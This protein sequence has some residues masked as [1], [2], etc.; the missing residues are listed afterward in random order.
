LARPSANRRG[1]SRSSRCSICSCSQCSAAP[2]PADTTV[3]LSIQSADL[4]KYPAFIPKDRTI[5]TV[6]NHASRAGK[7]VALLEKNGFTVAGGIGVQDYEAEG[8]TLVKI[9]PPAPKAA[10]GTASR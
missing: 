3:Y 5:I 7:A 9:V 6:S 1:S 4:E 2:T 8:G 10:A